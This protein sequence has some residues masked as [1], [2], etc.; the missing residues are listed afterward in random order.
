MRCGFRLRLVQDLRQ[1]GVR[2]FLIVSHHVGE[3]RLE[4]LDLHHAH[5]RLLRLNLQRAQLARTDDGAHGK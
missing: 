5:L 1:F 3:H 2:I 4:L